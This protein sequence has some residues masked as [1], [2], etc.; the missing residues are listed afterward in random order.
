MFLKKSCFP[1]CWNVSIVIPVFK[2]VGERSTAKNY[3]PV[4]F[5][6]VV[7]QGLIEV[8]TENGIPC[9]GASNLGAQIH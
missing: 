4:T 2:N 8:K 5:L 7:S 9:L 1:H 6:S 3:H